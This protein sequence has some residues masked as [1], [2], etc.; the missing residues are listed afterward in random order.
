[1]RTFLIPGF[2]EEP[3]IFDQIAP[4][5]PGPQV[6]LRNI[7]LMGS[8][9]RE[10]YDV[11]QHAEELVKAHQISAE[12]LLIGHSMGGW[13]AYAV[14]QLTGCRIVQ[15]GSWTDQGKVVRRIEN[16]R[17][18]YWLVRN[19]LYFNGF[20]KWLFTQRGYQGLPSEETFASV[21][22]NLI[23]SPIG[24]TINQLKVILTP[25]R[26]EDPVAPDLRIHALKDRVI[27]PPDDPFEEVPGDH[28]SLVTHPEE[29]L[30]PIK[31]VVG[32][33]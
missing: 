12:D 22:Q 4:S 1:M 25:I 33:F 9:T 13:I 31:D 26:F 32:V 29:V 18:V 14:K 28:F 16:L 17:L 11:K 23:G 6:F 5:L 27:L 21:F 15:I 2:G 20:N 8:G 7:E 24:Y 30:K 19:G 3:D 10:H